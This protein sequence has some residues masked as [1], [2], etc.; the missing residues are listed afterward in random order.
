MY[1]DYM[2]VGWEL[3]E[4]RLIAHNNWQKPIKLASYVLKQVDKDMG[5]VRNKCSIIRRKC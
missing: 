2:S 5:S 1:M 4:V 3:W